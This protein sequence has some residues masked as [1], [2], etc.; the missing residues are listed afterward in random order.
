VV[1]LLANGWSHAAG[2]THLTV[3]PCRWRA[4]HRAYAALVVISLWANF[5][6]GVYWELGASG[7]NSV[8]TKLD[9]AYFAVTVATTTG[10]GDI[11]P[12]SQAARA[13]VTC[14]MVT[15]FVLL[16]LGVRAL[17]SA[18]DDES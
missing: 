16:V 7:F 14:Q 9:A 4:T 8:L 18:D 15:G 1:P 5:F 12:V 2:E 13:A 11:H 6:A 17:R 3:V 10:F